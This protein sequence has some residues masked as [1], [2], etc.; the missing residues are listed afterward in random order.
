MFQEDIVRTHLPRKLGAMANSQNRSGVSLPLI[1]NRTGRPAEGLVEQLDQLLREAM[2]GASA[3]TGPSAIAISTDVLAQ[4]RQAV[5]EREQTIASMRERS[6]AMVRAQADAIVHSAEII[7]ELE[8]TKQ[9]LSEARQAAERAAEETKRLADTV[10]ERTNDGVLVFADETCVACNDNALELLGTTREAIIGSWPASLSMARH[11]DGSSA[12]SDIRQHFQAACPTAP[13][14]FEVQLPSAAGSWFWG[15]ITLSAFYM[16]SM[17]HVL[18][19]V[20]DITA[21]K[22]FEVEL[23]RHR[24]FLNNIINAVPDQLSVT[25]ADRALVLANAAYCLAHNVTPE[26]LFGSSAS[27]SLTPELRQGVEQIE[28]ELL[29]TGVCQTSEQPLIRA[30]GSRAVLSVKRSVFSGA[31]GDRYIVSAS[32]DITEDRQRE[33]RLRLLASVFNGASEGVAIIAADG[34]I[35]EANPAF[36]TMVGEQSQQIIGSQLNQIIRFEQ[37]NVGEVFESVAGGSTWTGKANLQGSG[38]R[39]RHFWVSLSP[40]T[41]CQEQ[42]ARV[43][44]LVSDITELEDA[45]AQL[46]SQALYDNLTGLPNRR[47]FRERLQA[48]IE[49]SLPPARGITVCFLDLDDFKHVNDSTGHAAGDSLLEEVGRRIKLTMGPEAFVARFGGDEFAMILTAPNINH[50]T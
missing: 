1:A 49:D 20:R 25:T 16:N 44:A 29:L 40:T 10:F 2:T 15:E 45:Q 31:Q 18:A 11:P 6:E 43:I 39:D 30:D 23:Q 50:L 24:D 9:S 19:V 48:V 37:S 12:G 38:T 28:R 27:E 35:C 17:G 26:E 5:A 7:D 13:I 47:C 21:R 42:A 36:M 4:L 34:R 3:V 46:V 32:R 41:D 33:D 8:R 22:E 14:L